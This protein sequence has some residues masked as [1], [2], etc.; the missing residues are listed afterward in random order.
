MLINIQPFL[1]LKH[2]KQLRFMVNLAGK[3]KFL[4]LCSG[5]KILFH[6]VITLIHL[7]VVLQRRIHLLLFKSLS[8]FKNILAGAVRR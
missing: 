7:S 8:F 1:C 2:D 6:E 5:S 4:C 3:K